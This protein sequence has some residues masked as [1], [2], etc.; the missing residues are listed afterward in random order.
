MSKKYKILAFIGARGGSKGLPGKNIA[1]A[2]GM[3]LIAYSIRPALESSYIDKVV[4][5]SDDD[6]ILN[7]SKKYGAQVIKRPEHL[8]RDNSRFEHA[9][10]HALDYLKENENYNPDLIILLQPTSPLRR[11]IDIDKSIASFLKSNAKSLIS[12]RKMSSNYLKIFLVNERGFLKGA[13]DDKFPFA[14]RHELPDVFWPDGSIYII[15]TKEFIKRKSMF[16]QETIPYIMPAHASMDI[17]YKEELLEFRKI[18]KQR[19][20]KAR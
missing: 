5:S 13:V 7:I 9:I 4:V 8:A 17:N 16:T 11:R 12:V 10:M 1:M 18:L 2:G 15:S 14:N 20:K 19:K 3:P 6:K